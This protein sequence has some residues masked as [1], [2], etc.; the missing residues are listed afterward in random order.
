[1][2]LDL[3]HLSRTLRRSRASAGAAIVTLA[4]TLGASASIFAVVDVVLLTPPPFAKP[5]SLVAISE[6]PLED[7]SAP[8]R[9]V[10]YGTFEAW[11]QRAGSLATLEASDGTNFTL[12]DLG[13]AERLSASYV[14]PGF[15]PLLGVTPVIGR[16]FAPDDVAQQVAIISDG[17]W[18][19]KLAGDPAV[20]GRRIV[21][22]GQPHTIVGVL[23]KQFV[24]TLNT[25][26]V[27]LPFAMPP[28]QAILTGQRVGVLGRLGKNVP[29][30]QLGLA[31]DDVSRASSP[32]AR[33]IA[34]P[35]AGVITADAAR[36]LPLLAGAAALAVLIAFTNFAGLLIVRSIDRGRELA[37]RTALGASRFEIVKQLLL[38]AQA[39]ALLGAIGGAI[40]AVWITPAVGRL[41]L[42]Q[43]GALANIDVQVSWRVLAVMALTAWASAWVCGAFAAM[44]ATRRRLADALRRGAAHAPRELALRRAFVTG[45]IAVA[46]VLLVSMMLVGRSLVRVLEVK[47]GFEADRVLT[48]SVSVPFG[49]YGTTERIVS[50]YTAL[51]S[52]LE[53]RLGRGAVSIIDEMPLTGDRGRAVVRPQ[54]M[55]PGREAVVREAGTAYFDV[56]RIPVLAGRAF[57]ER[58]N[59]STPL[60]VV[61]S[62]SLT[63]R[64]GLDQPVGRRIWLPGPSQVADVIGVVGDVKHRALDEAT[65]PTFYLS[66]WQTPSR[67]R[68]LLVRS[69]RPDADVV[70][71]V[72]EELGRL[73]RE[74]PI[75]GVI[76]MREVVG[77]SPGVPLRRVLTTTFMGFA[78]LAIVLGG[79]GLFGVVAHDV[80][81]R[82]SEIAVRIALGANPGRIL[83]ATLGQGAAMV[84]AGLVVGGLLSIWAAR[85]L[86]GV[87]VL[88]DRIDWLSVG[89]P[90]ALLIV[91]GA[92]AVLPAARRAARID[93]L[94]AL[95]SE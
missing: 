32:P 28:A 41:A 54:P 59:L 36:T 21:L 23:P 74:L 56:M 38:E 19:G 35:L 50:F 1:M 65:L 14:T 46:F 69:S 51:Q 47:P 44:I 94:T 45:E 88:A 93:P 25:V 42:V 92:V 37:V 63:L 16:S 77:R 39:L 40:L 73:D 2:L 49:S 68:H 31:L 83:G 17:F 7:P 85:A 6:T 52:A 95:R 55:D 67:S 91:A 4:L 33:A 20:L 84:A 15:L 18:R 76:P 70:A 34:R 26:D 75:Y 66:A 13:P 62:E 64:L 57:D 79:I 22:G 8:A 72:R 53:G 43:A 81:S 89:V 86:G 30:A 61:V 80:A 27:W 10:L 9:S 12:T 78:L 90:A 82:R 5:E 60:R 58:D 29:P 11:R 3:L 48:L 24:S 87:I 71:I